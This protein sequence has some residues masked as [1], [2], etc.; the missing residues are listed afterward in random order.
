LHGTFDPGALPA[1]RDLRRDRLG[2]ADWYPEPDFLPKLTMTADELPGGSW[3]PMLAA[4]GA[5]KI[6]LD[7][8]LSTTEFIAVG[9]TLGPLIPERAPAV[10]S[11][12]EEGVVLN[13]RMELAATGDVDLQPFAENFITLHTEGS[14]SALDLQPR[15]L[16]F[17]CLVPP[18]PGGGGQTLVL[19][20]RSLVDR[21]PAHV[22]ETLLGTTLAGT[23]GVPVFRRA[24]DRLVLCFRD[25]GDAPISWT[26]PASDP[27]LVN[28][29]LASLL[30][31]I[32]GAPDL[33]G[34]HW[35]APSLVVLDN[36]AVV[37]G[38]SK[39]RSAGG[40]VRRHIQRLRVRAA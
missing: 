17:L 24:G 11:F 28:Q 26:A 18:E 39:T 10:Q 13:L 36:T 2:R 14:L 6:L 3:R 35:T 22:I 34:I 7:R 37:H 4:S 20:V 27:D 40:H 21:L 30:L 12:V 29:A 23:A 33:A 9:R 16:V 15:Y 38:R 19:P 31:A 32:Y 8:G 25:R 1:L 5:A